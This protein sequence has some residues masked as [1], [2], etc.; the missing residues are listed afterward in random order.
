MA[1][2][3]SKSIGSGITKQSV[4]TV[5]YDDPRDAEEFGRQVKAFEATLDQAWA[6]R[7]HLIAGLRTRWHEVQ[8]ELEGLPRHTEEYKARFRERD[9]EEWY[10]REIDSIARVVEWAVKC[11]RPWEAAARSMQIGELLAEFRLK[12]EWD[13]DAVWGRAQ[14]IASAAG[15]AARR[16]HSIEERVAQVRRYLA[17]GH[18]LNAAFELAAVDLDVALQTV[19]RDWYLGKSKPAD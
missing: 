13:D 14:R 8:A 11:G 18:K 15:V 4:Q 5:R 16:R 17:Q 1:R 6:F 3:G 7:A 12:S 10:L 9:T 2:R 19:R